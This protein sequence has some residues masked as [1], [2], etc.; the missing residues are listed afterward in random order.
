M[1]HIDMRTFAAPF[2][3]AMALCA[4]PAAAKPTL[5]E[6]NQLRSDGNHA[7]AFERYRAVI[8][9]RDCDEKEGDVAQGVLDAARSAVRVNRLA[10]AETFIE[11]ARKRYRNAFGIRLA[12]A[13]AYDELPDGCEEVKGTLQRRNSGWS[14]LNCAAR[15]RIR[16]VRELENLMPMLRNA[17]PTRCNWYWRMMCAALQRGP[18]ATKSDLTVDPAVTAMPPPRPDVDDDGTGHPLFHALPESWAAAKSD[19]ERWRWALKMYGEVN[20]I[21]RELALKIRAD[22]AHSLFGAGRLSADDAI[23][24][25]VSSLADDESA[26]RF[27]NRLVRFKLPPD[28][29]FIRLQLEAKDWRGL[30]REMLD[31]LHYDRALECF[32]KLGDDFHVRQLSM[33]QVRLDEGDSCS[34]ERPLKFDLV[35]RNATNVVFKLTRLDADRQV[36][37]VLKEL[38]SRTRRARESW[39]WNTPLQFTP[40]GF[41]GNDP[42]QMKYLDKTCLEWS[43]ALEPDPAH[44]DRRVSLTAPRTVPGGIYML[45]ATA[46]DSTSRAIVSVSSVKVVCSNGSDSGCDAYAVEFDSGR[47]LSDARVTVTR[48]CHY[49]EDGKDTLSDPEEMVC[50]VDELGHFVV[51]PVQRGHAQGFITITRGTEKTYALFQHWYGWTPESHRDEEHTT[52]LTDRPVYRPGDT[53]RFKVWQMRASYDET[54]VGRF[55]MRPQTFYFM[56]PRGDNVNEF[57]ATWDDF[58]GFAGTYQI[59]EDAALGT[60]TLSAAGDSSVWGHCFRVEE[61]RKSEFEVKV[62]MPPEGQS[63][64]G[65]F[66]A[67]ISAAYFFGSPVADGIAHVRVTG[68]PRYCTWWPPDDWSWLYGPRTFSLWPWYSGKAR[69]CRFNGCHG[70]RPEEVVLDQ[71]ITL[72]DSGHARIAWDTASAKADCDGIDLEYTVD[73]KVRDSSRRTVA[74]SGTVLARAEP[75][76][77]FVWTDR[78]LCRVGEKVKANVHLDG[79][80][81]DGSG[82]TKTWKLFRIE[83]GGEER[84]VEIPG[85][86]FR[87]AERGQYR[88]SCEVADGKGE[89]REASAIVTV[90]GEADEARDFRF[91]DLELEP[92]R[93]TYAP[94]DVVK[95]SVLSDS[96][97]GYVF[98]SF[99]NSENGS[100]VTR[101]L[102]LSGKCS[103][104]EI[105]VVAADMPNFNVTAWTVRG[106]II[107]TAHVTIRVPPSSKV[108]R[109]EIE[110]P[111]EAQPGDEVEAVV[112]LFDAD[113]A[114]YDASG[115]L[116]VYDGAL[117]E[118]ASSSPGLQEIFW[119]WRRWFSNEYT[120]LEDFSGHWYRYSFCFNNEEPLCELGAFGAYSAD[121]NRT[122]RNG[123]RRNFAAA[124][125]KFSSAAVAAAPAAER[126]EFDGELQDAAEVKAK[127]RAGGSDA[128]SVRR[129]FVDTA[130][131]NAHLE[132][133]RE[134]VGVYRVRIKM[135]DD[136]TRWNARVW[137]LAENGR[138]AEC[139]AT[140]V[141]RKPLMLRLQSPRFY[142]ERDRSMLTA[143]LNNETDVEIDAEVRLE[144][145]EDGTARCWSSDATTRQVKVP[146]HGTARVDWRLE[147]SRA[148]TLKVRMTVAGG[149]LA[150]G[151]EKSFPVVPHGIEKTETLF[152]VSSSADAMVGTY[153]GEAAHER[154]RAA[155]GS[156]RVP[157]G[158]SE[159]VFTA[160]R[161]LADA[162]IDSL[163]YLRFYEY[164]CTEQTMNRFVPAV[165]A[166]RNLK[167]H[168]AYVDSLKRN[169]VDNLV[170]SGLRKLAEM[171]LS[172]GGWGWF[173]GMREV[174]GAHTTATV[175]RGLLL[176]REA[177]VEVDRKML[178]RALDRLAAF[179]RSRI[180]A[181]SLDKD[182]A[183]KPDAQDAFTAYVLVLGRYTGGETRRMIDALYAARDGLPFY[184]KCIL[185]RTFARMKDGPRRD[186]L[187]RNVRQHLRVD[188]E[189]A[190]CWFDIGSNDY[191]WWWYGSDFEAQAYG[192]ELLMDGAAATDEIAGVARYLYNHR[193]GRRHWLS[194]RDTGL[195][196]E[197]LSRYCAT[198]EQD[199]SARVYETGFVTY[200]DDAEDIEAAGLELKIDR[201]VSRVVRGGPGSSDSR[202]ALQNGAQ[203]ASGD[204]LEVRLDIDS[205]N[206]YEYLVIEDPRPAGC[207]FT[208]LL[209]G[210]QNLGGAWGYVELRDRNAVIFV[211]TMPRGAKSLVYRLRAETPGSYH[212]LPARIKAL[213]TPDRLR[214]NS[215]ENRIDIKE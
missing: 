65:K 162:V 35:F 77:V 16:L 164:E 193:R 197:A 82:V 210:Y 156:E 21:G 189:N 29:D 44:R 74:A 72:D 127:R 130:Y 112:R 13:Q 132:G 118:F 207:E 135:P 6:A 123:T 208:Q 20:E 202:V 138:V 167:A 113:G 161:T 184:A 115:V 14:S 128:L 12:C 41:T 151:V 28:Y 91:A 86:E 195:V 152:R 114:P 117:N 3:L 76:R 81:D 95:L 190:T 34:T 52:I 57:K 78:R 109:A 11:D 88:V 146:A 60:Y 40:G 83:A 148:G 105:P 37:D 180:D 119:G 4:V 71:E 30:G 79:L 102:R 141:T 67:E 2:A 55:P 94:G 174:S 198:F 145:L 23:A 158:A 124:P 203:I 126:A 47:P 18:L 129:N 36:S 196:I 170:R 24:I 188:E 149:G 133:S 201:T 62:G 8:L 163:D 106:G 7:E 144:I 99:R 9:A 92:D 42:E 98:V 27:G 137:T 181:L 176:A 212:V 101:M 58:G 56:N 153:T 120:M 104:M 22:F 191:W 147:A 51:P 211:N 154:M 175:A 59:P 5:A 96:P 142:V 172:D 171:Q 70:W 26:H 139:T 45:S 166:S 179:Q 73:V 38:R 178:E 187:V 205:K 177:G 80:S 213:Y 32:R 209:S 131:W 97:D 85:S 33:P 134:D 87:I 17:N 68:R 125:R 206:D 185:G 103:V 165:V 215:R 48:W 136:L 31:R 50:E 111:A 140:L 183:G 75:F 157:D 204:E 214:A 159:Y 107:H 64:G 15:D 116:S 150:D 155:F 108:G 89:T 169:E 186:M 122:R 53:V 54:V 84:E 39:R 49:V 182:N 61:Y 110:C 121:R 173:S 1:M 43:A 46:G 90:R 93:E 69:I 63:L 66:E 100:I 25:D 160:T 199:A 10:D 168:P 19:G 194:T 200:F 192:L 143:N